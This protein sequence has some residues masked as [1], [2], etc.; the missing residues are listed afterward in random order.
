MITV[1]KPLVALHRSGRLRARITLEYLATARQ[2]RQADLLVFCRNM[3]PRYSTALEAALAGGVP[4]LY[5]LDDNFFDIPPECPDAQSITPQ[6]LEMLS[7]YLRAA[8]L[9]R[10][11]SKPLAARVATLN[12]RVERT[13]AP[14]DLRLVPERGATTRSAAPVSIVYATRRVEDG[15]CDLFLP[16]LARV[17]RAA[18]GRVTAHFWGYKPAALDD[19][20]GACHHPTVTDYDRFLRRFSRAGFQIGLAPLGDDLFCRSK[21]NNKFREYAACGI[22][23]IYSNVDVYSDCVTDGRTG[24]LVQN[25]PEEWYRA[26]LRLVDDV[27]LR[28]AI[29][30]Q[31]QSYVREHYAQEK[32]E[33][34]FLR[35][36]ESVL[37]SPAGGGA[38]APSRPLAASQRPRRR[39]DNYLLR[40]AAT[41]WHVLAHLRRHGLRRTCQALAWTLGDQWMLL[42]LRCRLGCRRTPRLDVRPEAGGLRRP[43]YLHRGRQPSRSDA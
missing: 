14:V 26:M 35:Q 39:A 1:V 34:V 42:R 25:D 10:V 41:A 37:D 11:Y 4:M 6:R 7:A 22:A 30:Q 19:L 23:G 27:P 24:L 18:A 2:V 13:F 17:L 20:P 29:Q 36:I 12:P 8:S 28:R 15:L 31:A 3:E 5:D 21:T 32:F 38:T 16:A 40:W 43:A 33:E 9:V